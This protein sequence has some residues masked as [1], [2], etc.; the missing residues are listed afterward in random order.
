MKP[1]SR[2][3]RIGHHPTV[4]PVEFVAQIFGLLHL[5]KG[6]LDR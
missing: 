5:V 3:A 2:P 4:R 1:E 6:R